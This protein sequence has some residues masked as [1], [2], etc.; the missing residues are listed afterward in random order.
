ME[1]QEEIK[2]KNLPNCYLDTKY[3]E[4]LHFTSQANKAA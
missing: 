4:T 3:I 1:F 2:I